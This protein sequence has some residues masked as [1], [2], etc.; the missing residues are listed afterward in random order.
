MRLTDADTGVVRIGELDFT[1]SRGAGLRDARKHIQ[2][3]FQD[4]FTSLNP[5]RRVGRIIADGPI[6]HGVPRHRRLRVPRNC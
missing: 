2:M 3:V 4:P 1:Q 6:A 5:R